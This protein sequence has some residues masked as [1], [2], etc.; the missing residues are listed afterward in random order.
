MTDKPTPYDGTID[1]TGDKE[2]Y[3]CKSCVWKSCV[4]IDSVLYCVKGDGSAK[5]IKQ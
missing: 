2:K 4:S 1:R 5:W 3:I